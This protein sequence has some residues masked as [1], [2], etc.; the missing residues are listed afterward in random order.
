V[1]MYECERVKERERQKNIQ[2]VFYVYL[3]V[4]DRKTDRDRECVYES[5]SLYVCVRARIRRRKRQKLIVSGRESIRCVFCFFCIPPPIQCY[6]SVV[7]Y[8]FKER[9][10]HTHTQTFTLTQTFKHTLTHTRK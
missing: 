9:T 5:L 3:C 6:L 4:C 10:S 7:L 8:T 2:R 1:C